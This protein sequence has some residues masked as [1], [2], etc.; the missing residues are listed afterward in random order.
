MPRMGLKAKLIALVISVGT[1]PLV[2]AMVLSYFQ[3]NKSLINVI[4]SSFKALAQESGAKIDF[5]IKGEITKNAR[6]T[7]HPTLILAIKQQNNRLENIPE[8]EIVLPST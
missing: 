7:N 3:G 4:G 8:P 2:L 5:L 1:I 6:L